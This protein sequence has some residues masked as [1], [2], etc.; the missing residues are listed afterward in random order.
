MID[1]AFAGGHTPE[2]TTYLPYFEFDKSLAEYRNG[3]MD[4]ALAL[5]RNARALRPAP[6]LLAAMAEFRSGHEEEARQ[7]LTKA[8]ASFDWSQEKAIKSD[9]NQIWI[10]HVLRREA[11]SLISPQTVSRA[12]VRCLF[13]RPATSLRNVRR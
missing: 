5:T 13:R 6:Q 10:Y 9:D 4:A 11:E 1:R 12:T 3:H 7:M 2:F 8:I